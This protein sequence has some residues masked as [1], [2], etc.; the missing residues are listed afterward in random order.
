MISNDRGHSLGRYGVIQCIG[1][2]RALIVDSNDFKM[3]DF[4]AE[5][6]KE[7]E[8]AFFKKK[9]NFENGFVR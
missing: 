8:R 3:A 2:L 7:I 1:Y 6:E 5:L 4:G 9:K